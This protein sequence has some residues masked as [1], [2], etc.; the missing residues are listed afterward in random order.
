MSQSGTGSRWS[1]QEPKHTSIPLPFVDH[2]TWHGPAGFK[3]ALVTDDH[4]IA[5]GPDVV[6]IYTLPDCQL[7]HCLKAEGTKE[8]VVS[9]DA[10]YEAGS[11]TLV[12]ASYRNHVRFWDIGSGAYLGRVTFGT[13]PCLRV[14]VAFHLLILKPELVDKGQSGAVGKGRCPKEPLVLMWN[15]ASSALWIC[16]LPLAGGHG[17]GTVVSEGFGSYRPRNKFP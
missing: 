4:I 6:N 7:F 15:R 11:G 16:E 9:L 3:L 5:A 14:D 12:V 17:S 2:T 10:H 13:Q 1:T 8:P